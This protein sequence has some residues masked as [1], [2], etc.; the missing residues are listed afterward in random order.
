MLHSPGDIAALLPTA[1][2]FMAV[3]VFGGINSLLGATV[4]SELGTMMPQA[5][6]PYVF[7]RRAL[8]GYAGFFVGYTYWIQDCATDAALLL[9]IG[10]YL[11]VLVPA[12]AG[13]TVAV[14]FAMLVVLV[15]SQWRDVRWSGHIQTTTTIAK[16]GALGLLVVAA[17]VLPH[18]AVVPA[19]GAAA[20]PHGIALCVALVLAMQGVLADRAAP[21]RTR[22][23]AAVP[24]L[25]L[26][27]DHGACGP[28][29]PDVPRR[30][31]P[32]RC[33]SRHDRAGV[34]GR[35]LPAVSA[36]VEMD[37]RRSRCAVVKTAGA[38]LARDAMRSGRHVPESWR[39]PPR[40]RRRS[41]KM[42]FSPLEGR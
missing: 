25:G 33:A 31:G 29:R 22:H 27:V 20:V 18:P 5:G 12:L 13:H 24:G 23:T 19:A 30:R 6:G 28:D 17:F 35:Q 10:E 14:A 32:R 8:G 34:P 36:H 15:A 4:Y 26:S 37:A 40:R 42:N 3:W 21:A 38:L 11:P 16:V 41:G 2:L 39:R 1:T 9:L 7:A